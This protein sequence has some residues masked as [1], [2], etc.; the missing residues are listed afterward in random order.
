MAQ[1]RFFNT[2]RACLLLSAA[3][4]L[5]GC[6]VHL[7]EQAAPESTAQRYPIDRVLRDIVYTEPGW[8]QQLRADLYLPEKRGTLPV[9]MTIHGGGW[10]NRGREDMAD[11]SL[12]LAER[13]YAV[14]NLNYRFAPRY[15][16]P[17]QLEDLQQALGWI[18]ANASRYR[19]DP[20]RINAWGYSAGAHLAALL[21]SID[22]QRLPQSAAGDLPRLR[23]VV[24]GGIPADLRKYD[25]SPIIERFLGGSLD[26]IPERYAD[27]SPVYHV[28]ADDPAV[29]LYHG[30]FDLMVRIDQ[31]R[32]YY[33]ALIAAGV[34]AELYLHS[35][36]GHGTM[37]LFGGDAEDR[38]IDFL[39][40]Q[41][42][43][44]SLTAA[45]GS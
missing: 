2:L 37:F 23:A 26:E 32:D 39:D 6:Y 19:L 8:P 28:S 16:Y 1:S 14:L 29:F 9:V 24:A 44:D 43:P 4:L 13:G 17:A 21:G 30:R 27:A 18:S 11:I 20:E 3:L 45:A 25:S 22:R 31:P 35:L 42:R 36:R 7:N 15:T 34:D 33:D 12:E 40:R 38:A 10:A 41:N 5:S